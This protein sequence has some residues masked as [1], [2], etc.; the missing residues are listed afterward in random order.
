MRGQLSAMIIA[1]YTWLTA[2]EFWRGRNEPLVSRWPAIVLFF[3]P[4]R[5]VPAAHA[6]QRA[7]A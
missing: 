1:A 7:A 6:D 3:D 2:Y 5:D 4:R